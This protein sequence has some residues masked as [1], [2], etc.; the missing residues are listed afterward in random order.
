MTRLSIVVLALALAACGDRGEEA[1]EADSAEHGVLESDSAWTVDA[2]EPRLT[3]AE[4]AR[5]VRAIQRHSDSVRD[6]VRRE[7]VPPGEEAPRRRPS[8]PVDDSPRA[9][10]ESC[11]EQARQLEA[12]MRERI[13]AA[14]ERSRPQA[15][16]PN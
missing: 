1:E 10:Y 4:S 12:P 15:E 7:A 5:A 11:L 14:C 3:P 13:I 6:A 2:P 9:R 8:P 16:S